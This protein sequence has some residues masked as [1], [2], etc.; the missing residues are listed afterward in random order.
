MVKFLHG[1][2]NSTQNDVMKF[3]VWLLFGSILL[4]IIVPMYRLC[5]QMEAG[6]FGAKSAYAILQSL[7][8]D[9][10]NDADRNSVIYLENAYG[11]RYNVLGIPVNDSKYPRTWLLLTR[12]NAREIMM[13][14]SGKSFKIQC[15]YVQ[16]ISGRIDPVVFD[17]LMKNCM[18]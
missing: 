6:E 14:P 5:V 18:H 1:F 2:Q 15:S 17:F 3:L 4:I 8:S 16:H 9:H 13:V 10:R 7:E 11:T 12:T